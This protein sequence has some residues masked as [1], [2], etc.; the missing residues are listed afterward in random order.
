MSDD[1][2]AGNGDADPSST[3][4]GASRED[5]LPPRHAGAVWLTG[6]PGAGKSTVAA[7]LADRLAGRGVDHEVLSMDQV[8]GE[9]SPEGDEPSY[10]AE[11][12]DR[13]YRALVDR[14]AEAAR[15]TLVVVDATAHRREWRDALRARVED[16][17]GPDRFVE[18]HM[19]CPLEVAMEREAARTDHPAVADLY[20]RAL[21]RVRGGPVTA[22]DPDLGEVI[23]VDVPYEAPDDPEVH[24]DAEAV[25]PN[26]AAARILEALR[27][28]GLVRG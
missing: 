18:V 25:G 9:L 13:A 16:D 24:V 26:R 3:D 17:V 4:E 8:R 20:A 27:D 10:S 19:D 23:G 11:E 6:L 7:A 1:G 2:G 15:R 12:R 5:D 21:D 22:D 28:R 14:A